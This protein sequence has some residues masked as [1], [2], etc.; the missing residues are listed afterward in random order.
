[1]TRDAPLPVSLTSA[2][3]PPDFGLVRQI[4]IPP[5]RRTRAYTEAR[6][7]DT[8]IYDCRFDERPG[9]IVMVAPRR[10]NL[11][12]VLRGALRLDGAP[13]AGRL[14][15]RLYTRFELLSLGAGRD[16]AP[17]LDFGQGAAQDLR[18]GGLETDRFAG[19][20]VLLTKSWDNDI[21]RIVERA[22][23]HAFLHGADAAV[24][25]DNGSTRYS[26]EAVQ[27]ALQA[28]PEMEAVAAIP[29]PFRFGRRGGGRFAIPARFF[30]SAA[31]NIARMRLLGAAR[32][33]AARRRRALPGRRD[34]ARPGSASFW[35]ENSR[36]RQGAG[37]RPPQGVRARA[38]RVA[39]PGGE[40]P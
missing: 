18:P 22:R 40:T 3:L 30:Q 36:R 9:G 23:Q 33:S 13:A 34:G 1:M 2:R 14:R 25:F 20:N 37:E 27:A 24:I 11:W 17:S 10:P 31:L 19:R 5:E 6:D 21:G 35:Q 4:P 15:R 29:A 39:A 28:L 38:P 26:P 32:G 7:P 16:S 12:P 8:L